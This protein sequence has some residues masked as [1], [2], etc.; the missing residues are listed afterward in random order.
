M[1]IYG[2]QWQTTSGGN[3]NIQDIKLPIEQ[4][5]DEGTEL[6]YV[7]TPGVGY[8]CY[9]YYSE[10][11]EDISLPEESWVFKGPAWCTVEGEYV[12][13]QLP[14]GSAYW[15]K[16][17][18]ASTFMVSG[19]IP[20]SVNGVRTLETSG[21]NMSLYSIPFPVAGTINN[22]KLLEGC[23]DEGTE[24]IYVYTPGVGYDC[25]YYYS[26]SVEDISLP[27]ESWVFKG[28]AWCTVEGEYVNTPLALGQGFWLKTATD[29]TFTVESP[30]GK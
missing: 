9:Y 15:L 17:A 7:Y 19:M 20:Q 14:A 4:C 2:S 24:L 11:V 30:L 25:Y 23:T 22:V 27:E 26:E 28:P 8:D 3:I 12:S 5:T 16:T 6:L 13:V 1:S 21:G 29:L 18:N 10:S